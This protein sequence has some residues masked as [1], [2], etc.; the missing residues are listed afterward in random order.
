MI[1]EAAREFTNNE[2]LPVANKLDPVKGD[3]PDEMV[4]HLAE[5]GFFGIRIPEEY[6]GLGLG[7]FEYCLVAEELS[8][9]WMSVGS[10]IARGNTILGV[11][12]MTEEQKREILPLVAQGKIITAGAL[13]EPNVG[14]DLA[15][16]SCSARRDGDDWV[17]TGNKYWVTYGDKADIIFVVARTAPAES[18]KRRHKGLSIFSVRKER[19]SFPK[20]LTGAPIP[21]IGYFGFKTYELAFDNLR[22]PADALV[23]EEGNAFYYLTRGLETAR[24]H[25]AARSIGQ[26]QGALDVAVEY[27]KDRVQFGEPISN[28]Q[29]IRFKIATMATEIESARQLM[30]HVCQ[31]IDTGQRCDR[32]AAM[33]KYLAAEMSERVTSEALQILGGAGYTQLFPVERY[34]RD[35]RLTKIFEGTSEIQLRIISDHILGKPVE[36]K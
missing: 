25:T 4:E 26:A 9:G 31:Q 7:T 14:S 23:G 8:R 36:K 33:V 21:K 24:A 22:L 15:G 20:G 32:E 18:P 1:Q 28:F 29:A 27:A 13:S 5:M 3:I 10:I 2:V 11:E 6:G 34:W 17:I 30:Y 16:I 19:G 35:A 12:A